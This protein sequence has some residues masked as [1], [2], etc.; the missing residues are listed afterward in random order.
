MLITKIAAAPNLSSSFVSLHLSPCML[1]TEKLLPLLVSLFHL[2]PCMLVPKISLLHL[3]PM[4]VSLLVPKM[5]PFICRGF[6][7]SPFFICLPSLVSLLAHSQTPCM[8]ITEI[9]AAPSLSSSFVS[10]FSPN[11]FT[12]FILGCPWLPLPPCLPSSSPFMI[13]I[14][15]CCWL[16]LPPCPPS[17][18]FQP[19][20]CSLLALPP[21][22]PRLFFGNAS[23][24]YAGIIYW[25]IIIKYIKVKEYILMAFMHAGREAVILGFRTQGDK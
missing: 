11:S 22:L 2:S 8:L 18:V 9:A 23:G 7:K 14:L 3:S 6:P 10:L 19:C 1:I 21:R 13:S 25:S 15:V 17:F 16:P 24:V 4:F 5:S 20:L 12:F